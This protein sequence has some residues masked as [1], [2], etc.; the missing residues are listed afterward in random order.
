MKTTARLT[1][2]FADAAQARAIASAVALDDLG[3]IRTTLRGKTILAAA[4]ADGPMSLL[5]TLDDYLACVSVAERTTEEARP[6]G[7]AQRR[8]A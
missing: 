1:L 5:H 8:R 3:Y 2:T 7:R 6:R 4:S